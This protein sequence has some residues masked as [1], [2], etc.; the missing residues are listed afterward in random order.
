MPKQIYHPYHLWEDYKAGFYDNIS[1][2]NTELLISKVIELFSNPILTKKYMN[3]VIEQWQYSC[4]HNLTNLSINRIAYIGQSAC[5]LY[6]SIPSTIT[7]QA[8]SKV[9]KKYRDIAD[10][11]AK[12][13]IEKWEQQQ[14]N[15]LQLCLK[16]D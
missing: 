11:I 5:C 7:M 6:A 8:W 15:K 1:G 12:E 13:T 4:E 9:D 16:L 2:K 10:Q 14:F 3:M